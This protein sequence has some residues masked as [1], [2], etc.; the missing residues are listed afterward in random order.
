MDAATLH[1]Y[2]D[3]LVKLARRQQPPLPDR[4]PIRK[5]Q[6]KELA[7]SAA[8]VGL[9]TAGG[10]AVGGLGGYAGRRFMLKRYLSMTPGQQRLYRRLAPG[11]AALIMGGLGTAASLAAQLANS[12]R[13]YRMQRA[14]RLPRKPE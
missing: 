10:I 5:G 14:G 4:R 9:G 3:E 2:S 11:R 8:L 12:E 7:R 1:A 13:S 6:G